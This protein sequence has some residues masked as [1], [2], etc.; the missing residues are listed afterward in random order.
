MMLQPKKSNHRRSSQEATAYHEAGHVVAAIE[1]KR[2]VLRATIVP[3]HTAGTAGRATYDKRSIRWIGKVHECAV[4]LSHAVDDIVISIC[5]AVAQ[6]RYR[7][8]SVRSV[9][10]HADFVSAFDMALQVSGS[11]Q[12]EAQ[13][14]LRW[15]EVR[16]ENLVNSRWPCIEAV[17][18][19]LLR[20]RTLDTDAIFAAFESAD[21]EAIVRQVEEGA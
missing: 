13:A 7:P 12:R 18:K 14:L 11:E 2:R 9:H 15:L 16:A 10:G 21:A 1:L 20:D 3:D 19:A 4:P 17:A 8:R 6:R 5:G